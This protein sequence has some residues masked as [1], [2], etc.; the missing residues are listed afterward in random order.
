MI[1][2]TGLA[3]VALL[4][5]ATSQLA[6]SAAVGYPLESANIDVGNQRS[7]QRGA[8]TFVNYCMS[9]HSLGFMRY[10]RVAE[11]LGIPPKLVEDNLIFGIDD[12]GS[13]LKVTSMMN[14]TMSTDY[15]KMAFGVAPPDLSLT[16]RSRGED[17]LYTYLKTFYVDEGRAGLGSNNA[18]LK[19]SAMPNVLW[20]LQGMQAPVYAEDGDRLVGVELVSEGSQSVQ[21]FDK[22]ITDLVAFLSYVSEPGQE[23]RRAIGFWVIL[24]MLVFTGLAWMLKKEYWR[25]VH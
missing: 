7:L 14:S 19:G 12:K 13:S 25:D 16:A 10:A 15:G 4:A 22:T 9:C 18:V 6:N 8:Q 1:R 5:M 11:D 24:F 2:S 3:V 21:E 23:R 17:W 20:Q